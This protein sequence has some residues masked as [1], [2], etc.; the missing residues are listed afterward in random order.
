MHHIAASGFFFISLQTVQVSQMQK[1][2]VYYIVYRRDCYIAIAVTYIFPFL[3]TYVA[4]YIYS[5]YLQ[6]AA[7]STPNDGYLPFHAIF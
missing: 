6:H 7:F 2:G 1:T 3:V 5:M 4:V